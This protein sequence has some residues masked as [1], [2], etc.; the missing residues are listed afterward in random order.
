MIRRRRSTRFVLPLVTGLVALFVLQGCSSSADTIG[1]SSLKKPGVK[2]SSPKFAQPQ[3]PQIPKSPP[4]ESKPSQRV[5]VYFSTSDAAKLVG[6]TSEVGDGAD[7]PGKAVGLLIEGPTSKNLR[8]TIPQGTRL[9][10]VQV[11]DKVAYVDFSKE[12]VDNHPGG[13]AAEI[14]TVY[15]VVDTL[16]AL[17]GIDKVAFK[18][19]AK[20]LL[21]LK[22]QLDL[23]EPLGK[24]ES[25]ISG[26]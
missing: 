3:K 13:S 23:T 26:R 6:E 20:P 4:A 1:K 10:G 5:T 2:S 21:L 9:L 15:S 14:M 19:N 12:F 16:T 17:P 18:V 25:L 7:L 22:G 24:D 8:P 11:T